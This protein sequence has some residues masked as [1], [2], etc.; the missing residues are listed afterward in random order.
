MDYKISDFYPGATKR[1]KATIKLDNVIQDISLDTVTLTIK[2]EKSDLDTAAVLQV[3]AD[4]ETLG[5]EG[6]AL[7]EFD[8]EDTA[9]IPPGQYYI[10]I[11]WFDGVDEYVV[12]DDEIRILQ[13]ISDV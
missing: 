6:I 5:D 3:D 2:C 9:D 8:E 10:D 12:Y 11:Q 1:F 4:V 13:R 7:F